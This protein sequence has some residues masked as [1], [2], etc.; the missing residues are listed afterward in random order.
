[1][2][3]PGEKEL[4]LYSNH[5]LS[6]IDR[7]RVRW[8]VKSCNRCA[9]DVS[10]FEAVGFAVRSSTDE[11]PAGLRWENLAA[12]M[13]ANIH[14][15]LEA[16]E[17]VGP[18]PVNRSERMGWRAALVMASMTIVLLA[19]WWLNP[20]HHRELA[21]HRSPAEIR[22]AP[23]GIEVKENGS[24]LTLLHTRGQQTPI[25]VSTPGSLRAR[26][27]D[28]DTGQVTINNVYSD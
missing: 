25:I 13:T 28:A 11:L 6:W 26:F 2:T 27:V 12:E 15:G 18:V 22:T 5:D 21:V 8:H 10:A 4:A 17:C 14:L 23:E 20:P 1:M 16:G 9:D 24:A 19:A 3:H 7:L